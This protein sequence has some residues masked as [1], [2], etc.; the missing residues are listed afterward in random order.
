M[1]SFIAEG[2]REVPKTPSNREIKYSDEAIAAQLLIINKEEDSE[3][4][5]LHQENNQD[6]KLIAPSEVMD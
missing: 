5:L 3:R 6:H 1:A 2:I 4:I